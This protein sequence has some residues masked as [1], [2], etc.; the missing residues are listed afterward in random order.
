M[1]RKTYKFRLGS[2]DDPFFKA[3]DCDS[4]EVSELAHSTYQVSSVA[5]GVWGDKR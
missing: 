1:T 5:R 2:G 4:E 3:M